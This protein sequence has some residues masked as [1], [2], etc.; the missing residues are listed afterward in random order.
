MVQGSVWPRFLILYHGGHH[1][2]IHTVTGSIHLGSRRPS[3]AAFIQ[4]SQAQKDLQSF[5]CNLLSCNLHCQL[6]KLRLT[7]FFFCLD[8]D[9]TTW[10]IWSWKTSSSPHLEVLQIQFR[11]KLRRFAVVLL[12]LGFSYRHEKELNLCHFAFVV[13]TSGHIQRALFIEGG[14]VIKI[15]RAQSPNQTILTWWP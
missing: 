7:T 10:S 8:N 15:R 3:M 6:H 1:H 13:L 12:E 2:H 4:N 11:L 5:A 14:Q 9:W